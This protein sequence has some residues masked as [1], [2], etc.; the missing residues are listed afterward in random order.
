MFVPTVECLSITVQN[1][2]RAELDTRR[3][4]SH[5]SADSGVSYALTDNHIFGSW[6]TSMICDIAN[7]LEVKPCPILNLLK[8]DVE[9]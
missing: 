8:C 4:S 5:S 6:L 7:S 2:L 9:T 3:M 1:D